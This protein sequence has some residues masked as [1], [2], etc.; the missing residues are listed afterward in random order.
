VK[1]YRFS[2]SWARIAPY[3][4]MNSLNLEGIA[5]YNHLIDELIKNDIIPLVK[6]YL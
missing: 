4:V 3:G 5:Y 1:V 6:I 2:I